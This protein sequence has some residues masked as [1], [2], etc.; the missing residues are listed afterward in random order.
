MDIERLKD[1]YKK[2]LVV[3]TEHAEMRLQERNNTI[4]DIADAINNGEII[5]NYDEDEPFPSCLILYLKDKK[6]IHVVVSDAKEY[7]KIVT[8]YIPNKEKWFDG[9]KKRVIV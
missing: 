7:I 2:D 9:F 3:I 1:L 8:A 6:P 5:E 4:K